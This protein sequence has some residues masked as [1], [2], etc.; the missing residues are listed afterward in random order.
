MTELKLKC[1]D[2]KNK[3][4]I[5]GFYLASINFEEKVISKIVPPPHWERQGATYY[6][7]VKFEDIYFCK[8]TG[9]MDNKGK[10]IFEGDVL[11]CKDFYCLVLYDK[12]W[13]GFIAVNEKESY[14]EYLA[15]FFKDIDNIAIVGSILKDSFIEKVG[16]IDISAW[17]RELYNDK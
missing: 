7:G 13:G 17:T 15:T 2:K 8:C 6:K 9:L 4:F 5:E 11:C 12:L 1:F 3:E 14:V 16:D 10:E